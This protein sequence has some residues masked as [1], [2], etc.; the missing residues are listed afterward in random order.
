[1]LCKWQG[2]FHNKVSAG[3]RIRL[4]SDRTSDGASLLAQIAVSI[5]HRRDQLLEKAD[6]LACNPV[7]LT[8]LPKM[9]CDVGAMGKCPRSLWLL[10]RIHRASAIP[11]ERKL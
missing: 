3:P 9:N 11:A 5:F 10:T 4:L 2:F 8:R 7:T 6:Y 1:M